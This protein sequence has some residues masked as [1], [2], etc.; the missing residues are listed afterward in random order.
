MTKPMCQLLATLLTAVL[1]SVLVVAAPPAQAQVGVQRQTWTVPNA[2]G[3]TDSVPGLLFYPSAATATAQQWGP[4]ALTVAPGAA[5]LPGRHPLVLI[6]HGTGGHELGHAWLAQA[7]A[8]EGYIVVA[9][10]HGGDNYLDR[11]AV[12]RPDFL[13]ERPRQASRVLDALLA[14][15][16]WAPLLDSRR[17]A[18]FGHSAGGHTVLALAGAAVD[19]QR[20]LMHCGAS[21]AGLQD[22][23]ELCRLAGF[24]AEHPAPAP[25]QPAAPATSLRDT[26]VRAVVADAPMTLAL[27]AAAWPALAVPTLVSY[28]GHD[29]VLVP[30]FH[31]EP[32]C[33]AAPQIHCL[34]SADAGHFASFQAGTGP[35]GAGLADP[36]ADPPGFDRRAWQA[37]A[38]PRIRDFLAQALATGAEAAPPARP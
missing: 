2:S 30:R 18:A 10:R 26:R 9:L 33:A 14:D 13:V 28:G 29:A 6:S 19:G 35:L 37:Q 21:G 27:D 17:I 24:S 20:L 12:A 25:R 38:W 32:L 15:A 8:G 4:F 11:S 3:G 36:A 34:R 22:D 16:R 5:P 7:L 23:G 31:A 1:A